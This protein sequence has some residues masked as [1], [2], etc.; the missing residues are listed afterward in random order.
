MMT[1][2]HFRAVE[3]HMLS[4][5][6]IEVLVIGLPKVEFLK[7]EYTT[8]LRLADEKKLG[9]SKVVGQL[10]DLTKGILGKMMLST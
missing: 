2:T 1:V 9:V 7:R 4:L 10:R 3:A 5:Y 8:L 6:K